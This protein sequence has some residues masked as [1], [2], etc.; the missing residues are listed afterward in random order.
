MVCFYLVYTGIQSKILISSWQFPLLQPGCH[1]I[2]EQLRI[3]LIPRVPH[4][5]YLFR[6]ALRIPF[7]QDFANVSRHI[8][9]IVRR[10]YP[11]LRRRHNQRPRLQRPHL[12]RCQHLNHPPAQL[13]R[14]RRPRHLLLL[15]S[16]GAAIPHPLPSLLN[17]P[18]TRLTTHSDTTPSARAHRNTAH[19][20][21]SRTAAG[22]APLHQVGEQREGGGEAEARDGVGAQRG[23][24]ARQRGNE[25][26]VRGGE[27]GSGG[28]VGGGGVVEAPWRRRV[29]SRVGR[30]GGGGG[31]GEGIVVLRSGRDARRVEGGRSR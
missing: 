2:R 4:R 12:L 1:K 11:T 7:L 17:N 18:S 6:C 14:L 13:Q 23:A 3:L 28:E 19:G 26:L 9:T 15:P 24:V 22:A 8:N 31:G 21:S 29:V 25:D 10:N 27:V 5:R 20:T 16:S 30:V